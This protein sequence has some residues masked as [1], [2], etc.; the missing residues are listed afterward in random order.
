M[1]L[2]YAVF[3][4]VKGC[5]LFVYLFFSQGLQATQVFINSLGRYGNAPFLFPIFGGGELP[6][7]FCRY[8]I[9]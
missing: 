9:M 2:S 3:L 7:A 1:A 6:Q 4:L 8:S 5:F